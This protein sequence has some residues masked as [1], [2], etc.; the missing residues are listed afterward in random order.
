MIAS[1][2]AEPPVQRAKRPRLHRA[3][4]CLCP[5]WGGVTLRGYKRCG[6]FDA[7]ELVFGCDRRVPRVS[8]EALVDYT[9]R[10]LQEHGLDFV[11]DEHDATG[12]NVPYAGEA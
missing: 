10:Y 1:S 4:A 11:F 5:V 6:M 12:E 7:V 2:L 9:L 3:C 8:R